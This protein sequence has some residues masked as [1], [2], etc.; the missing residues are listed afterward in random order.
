MIFFN[1]HILIILMFI[2]SSCKTGELESNVINNDVTIQE[3]SKNNRELYLDT[4]LKYDFPINNSLDSGF[5]YIDNESAPSIT[6]NQ[7]LIDSSSLY[8][9]DSYHGNIKRLDLITNNVTC[10]EIID[11]S[12]GILSVF[13]FFQNKI[14]VFD[15]KGNYY[16]LDRNMKVLATKFISDYKGSKFIFNQNKDSLFIYRND[17]VSQENKKNINIVARAFF[18]DTSNI[19]FLN[20]KSYESFDNYLKQNLRGMSYTTDK[21]GEKFSMINQF[22]KFYMPQNIEK[23]NFYFEGVNFDFNKEMIAYFNIKDF[24]FSVTVFK[25]RS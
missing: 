20:F 7:V 3:S 11:K 19:E 16:I 1:K 2:V 9:L 4:V 14:Y 22:G 13:S 15:E 8:F 25:Y 10:S 21:T 12:K 23:P 5:G 24:V 17:D 6:I 18:K